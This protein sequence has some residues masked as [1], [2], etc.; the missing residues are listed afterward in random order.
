M[1]NVLEFDSELELYL[2]DFIVR[3]VSKELENNN[4]KTSK[5]DLCRYYK[6]AFK[7]VLR[8]EKIYDYD[9]WRMAKC[10]GSENQERRENIVLEGGYKPVENSMTLKK[11]FQLLDRYKNDWTD[12]NVY[13]REALFY[14]QFMRISPYEHDNERIA[15]VIINS[16]LIKSG[17][18]PVIFFEQ[19]GEAYNAFLDN[20]D[21][22]TFANFLEKRSKEEATKNGKSK[23]LYKQ[24]ILVYK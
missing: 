18:F 21:Y 22:I 12:L 10:F 2:N 16:N 19:Y 8:L 5:D 17:C 6:E 15:K 3:F 11:K 20:G 24:P 1:E 14:I 7:C 4:I 13:Q 9:I 23:I